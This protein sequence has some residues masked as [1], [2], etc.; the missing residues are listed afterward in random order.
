MTYRNKKTGAVVDTACKV[1]GANW[2]EVKRGEPGRSDTA[3]TT[4]T[5]AKT[6]KDDKT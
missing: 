6:G 1:C 3:A 2:E 4:K 5:K